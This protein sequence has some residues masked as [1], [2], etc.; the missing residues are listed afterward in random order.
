M[1]SVPA[2]VRRLVGKVFSLQKKTGA[3][4]RLLFC[5]LVSLLI[6]L[7]FSRLDLQGIQGDIGYQSPIRAANT[8]ELHVRLVN[9]TP[10]QQPH[11]PSEVVLSPIPGSLQNA[12][13]PVSITGQENASE[14]HTSRAAAGLPLALPYYPVEQLTEHPRFEDVPP[15]DSSDMPDSEHLGSLIVSLYLGSNG[16]IDRID[17]DTSSMTSSQESW[18]LEKLKK[19]S[20]RP[21]R[22]AGK[23][24]PSKWVLEFKWGPTS[25]TQASPDQSSPQ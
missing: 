2:S 23:P 24:V 5:L 19:L 25:G 12:V 11:S 14:K 8:T 7:L 15:E 4:R 21:G 9:A 10:T 16:H 22:L 1:F 13:P 6:H 20:L 17:V 3:L 18:L